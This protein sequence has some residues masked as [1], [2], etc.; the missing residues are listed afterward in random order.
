VR[1]TILLSYMLAMFYM[2]AEGYNGKQDFAK[3][4]IWFRKAAEQNSALAQCM[5][6]RLYED[7]NGV[8]Q[9]YAEAI[10]WYRK[11]AEQENDKALNALG[12]MYE[13]GLGVEQSYEAAFKWYG[14]AAIRGNAGGLK[15]FDRM[16]DMMG[17]SP[18][19][20]TA[21]DAEN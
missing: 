1:N 6:G 14:E 20:T 21:V 10:N 2:N 7:G 17:F 3:A 4:A 8:K 19:T 11:A 9:D 18:N 15:N 13:S 16:L 5:L 12:L